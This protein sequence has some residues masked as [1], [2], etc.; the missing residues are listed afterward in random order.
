M[1][2]R[3]VNRT[4]ASSLARRFGGAPPFNPTS[5][6]GC[7]LWLDGSDT[8][9]MTFSGS[10][11][12]QWNDKSGNTKNAVSTGT[13]TYL[14]GGGVNFNGSSYFLNQTFIMNLSQRSVF[15]VFKETSQTQYAGI[16]P[17]IPTLPEQFDQSQTS[18]LSYATTDSSFQVYGNNSYGLYIG[19]AN[20][21]PKAIYNEIM[22]ITEG[23]GYLNG[24]NT[25]N[26]TATYTAGTCSGYGL[27][28][29]WQEGSVFGSLR[30]NGVIY[31][32][33]VFNTPLITFQRQQTE[34]YLAHKWG[35][36]SSLPS[37][38]PY[39]SAAP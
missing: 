10:T 38:H 14:T 22:N 36:Q 8:S 29:R 25:T 35:L 4:Q 23:S 6:T 5:I 39:K 11:I 32:I 27:A 20:P 7:Q 24:T 21:L 13:P 15:I 33:V 28:C 16:F 34:G 17:L 9:S 2:R 31:E 19:N 1:R 26:V 12:T 30:L 3:Q 37:N 18:G